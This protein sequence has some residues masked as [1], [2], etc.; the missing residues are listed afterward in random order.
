MPLPVLMKA[1]SATLLGQPNRSARDYKKLFSENSNIVFS[2]GSDVRIYHA[3]A[4]LYYRLEFLWRNQRIE[5]SYKIYRFYILWGLWQNILENRNILHVRKP[6]EIGNLMKLVIDAA[7][8]EKEFKRLVNQTVKK[9]TRSVGRGSSDN[10]EK[11]RDLIR[12]DSF[13]ASLKTSF[14]E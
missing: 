3:I 6:N 12:S 9:M 5:A 10:R 4:F 13:F 11:L 1:V 8:D 14:A 2:D 7:S